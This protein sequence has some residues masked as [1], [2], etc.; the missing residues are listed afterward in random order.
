MPIKLRQT[1]SLI[2][3]PTGP[4]AGWPVTT[5]APDT[6]VQYNDNNVFA[7]SA[8]FTF[9][10]SGPRLHLTGS[11]SQGDGTYSDGM[12]SH[13]EGSGTAANGMY[14]HAE[15]STTIATGDY[16]HAEGNSTEASGQSSHA[17]GIGSISSGNFS[18]AEGE[19]SESSGASSHAEGYQT[20]S[21][22][23][24]SHAEGDNT[25]AA[26]VASHAE[27]YFTVAAGDYSHAE[28]DQSVSSANYS[29]A[30]GLG[31]DS[32]G[33][34]SHAEGYY[35][36]ALGDYSHAEGGLTIASGEASHAEGYQTEASGIAAHAE[37]Y[38]SI[39]LGNFSHAEGLGTIASGSYQ[40]VFGRYNERDNTSSVFVIGVGS[41]DS[42]ADRADVVRVELDAAN[43]ATLGFFDV[44]GS[45]RMKT[46]NYSGES[47]T[48][49]AAGTLSAYR[50]LS[51]VNTPL[52]SAYDITLP[53]GVNQG[54]IKYIVCA[55]QTLSANP[56]IIPSSGNILG[57]T[58]GITLTNE[59]SGITLVWLGTAWAIVG[60]NDVTIV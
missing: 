34:S 5:G 35:S 17:E 42:T 4:L 47:E 8:N 15:G 25:V 43:P 6:A 46:G 57:V 16:S 58:T 13:A 23:D 55:L 38:Q 9:Y 19:E 45:I 3:Y 29:H 51:I 31:A 48:R 44:T 7:G 36:T 10:A 12:Y 11:L 39:A 59:G 54:Q 56:R 24:Y 40:S 20:E 32:S 21:S 50:H 26:G 41:S 27:G 2:V 33:A 28:G 1:G 53:D 52:G 60:S 37:G 22:N 14:S 49:T 18:H 30:E